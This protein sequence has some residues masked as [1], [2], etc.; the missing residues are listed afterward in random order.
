L[1]DEHRFLEQQPPGT[2]A[3]DDRV[4]VPNLVDLLH[5]AHIDDEAGT[6]LRLAVRGVALAASRH[7]DVPRSAELDHLGDVVDRAGAQHRPRRVEDDEAEVAALR[8]QRCVVGE[9]LAVERG[10]MVERIVV[11]MSAHPG[12][13]LPAVANDD[14]R[15]SRTRRLQELTPND[16]LTA[17]RFPP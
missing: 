2:T 3:V 9:Q 15:R 6:G 11:V 7:D 13:G 1:A 10:H 8:C 14:G 17:H 5:R 16:V 12:A 4:A